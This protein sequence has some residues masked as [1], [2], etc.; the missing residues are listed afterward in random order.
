ME[1]RKIQKH[2]KVQYPKKNNIHET[3]FHEWEWEC[4]FCLFI[5]VWYIDKLQCGEKSVGNDGRFLPELGGIVSDPSESSKSLGME[6][7]FAI[8]KNVPNLSTLFR[9]GEAF[10]HTHNKIMALYG[11]DEFRLLDFILN[12][13]MNIQQPTIIEIARVGFPGEML[14]QMFLHLHVGPPELI[15]TWLW[16]SW[17]PIPSVN[18]GVFLNQHRFFLICFFQAGW[19]LLPCWNLGICRTCFHVNGLIPAISGFFG[20][21]V[22]VF[23][24]NVVGTHAK[25]RE[26]CMTFFCF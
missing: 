20:G 15:L 14:A 13:W 10:F 16:L 19:F 2:P 11:V 24:L 26:S 6:S 17:I 7:Q 1:N 5:T 4:F 8:Q 25:H 12:F 23:V 21:P 3:R 18:S 9:N 22:V